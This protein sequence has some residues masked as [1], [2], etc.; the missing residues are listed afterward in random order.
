M[1]VCSHRQSVVV[2]LKKKNSYCSWNFVPNSPVY[3]SIFTYIC[4]AIRDTG[5]RRERTDPM[6]HRHRISTCKCVEIN[7]SCSVPIK[8]THDSL[9]S[10]SYFRSCWISII[11][12]FIFIF[13]SHIW[14]VK[15]T[16]THVLS[17]V[18]LSFFLSV[19]LFWWCHWMLRSPAQVTLPCAGGDQGLSGPIETHKHGLIEPCRGLSRLAGRLTCVPS[20]MTWLQQFWHP[21]SPCAQSSRF[22]F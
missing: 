2:Y 8:H 13:S 22:F 21:L 10:I 20:V 7:Q 5:T 15:T 6:R 11:L 4:G 17:A 3:I 9:S 19:F 12:F 16:L 1:V 18:R 14:L